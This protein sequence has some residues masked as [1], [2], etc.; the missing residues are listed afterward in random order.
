MSF[1]D[2]FKDSFLEGTSS[3][4]ALNIGVT[5][6]LSFVI[7]LFIFQ[8]Y[9]K[10]YQSVVYTKSFNMSLV[11]MTMITALVIMAVTSNVVLSLGMVGALSIVRFRAAIKDP[12]DIVFMFWAIASGIVTGAGFFLL[13]TIGAFVIG[14]ILYI[15]NLNLKSETPYILLV[16]FSNQADETEVI[17]SIKSK[18]AKYF[19]KSKTVDSSQIEL[20]IELRLKGEEIS[21]VNDLKSIESVTHAML[22]SSSEYS[23]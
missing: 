10:T 7:G 14:T 5:L 13:A 6:L 18:V 21:F 12:M 17:N 11:M 8:V 1:Q 20:T 23:C 3:L 9:K 4:S 2:I 16:N 22:V 19:V 15:F